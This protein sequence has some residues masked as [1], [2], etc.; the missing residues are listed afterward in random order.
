MTWMLSNVCI[1]CLKPNL[2]TLLINIAC[3][4]D[5]FDVLFLKGKNVWY[6]YR[7]YVRNYLLIS[8]FFSCF[9][10]STHSCHSFVALFVPHL[11]H[12][13]R[14]LIMNQQYVLCSNTLLSY[15]R[16]SL[17]IFFISNQTCNNGGGLPTHS[18][19]SLLSKTHLWK[20]Y[21]WLDRNLF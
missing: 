15:C 10:T 9:C 20:W 14:D 4:L 17:Y 19:N 5:V 1:V 13:H 21:Q 6:L 2:W 8:I 16:F 12:D 18:E 3:V 7:W 11:A